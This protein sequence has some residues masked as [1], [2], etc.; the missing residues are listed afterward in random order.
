MN[1]SSVQS[2]YCL[3]IC[4]K[5]EILKK[6]NYLLSI[7]LVIHI[8][9]KVF[10]GQSHC[11]YHHLRHACFASVFLSLKRVSTFCS[12]FLTEYSSSI[13]TRD[14]RV[15]LI[16]TVK[17]HCLLPFFHHSPP[18]HCA[19]RYSTKCT[20]ASSVARCLN[21]PLAYLLC[22]SALLRNINPSLPVT[23]VFLCKCRGG[24]IVPG[25]ACT[26]PFVLSPF[27]PP[28]RD[29]P[30]VQVETLPSTLPAG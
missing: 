20:A 22:S 4:N 18:T 9:I 7:K 15:F 28:S 2:F 3:Q 23:V 24:Q 5:A 12:D 1:V 26:W 10:L 21:V 19:A 11:E 25:L 27:G 17:R 16:S 6:D 29:R 8:E 14:T 30:C 13:L